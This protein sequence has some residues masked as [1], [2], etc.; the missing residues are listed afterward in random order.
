[1]TTAITAL[2]RGPY[3]IPFRKMSALPTVSPS[4]RSQ[5]KRPGEK[6]LQ[7]E[8]PLQMA[9]KANRLICLRVCGKSYVTFRWV[10]GG[11]NPARPP[12]PPWPIRSRGIETMLIANAVVDS[13]RHH[14]EGKEMEREG[15]VGGGRRRC[16]PSGARARRKRACLAASLFL[17]RSPWRYVY[18]RAEMW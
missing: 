12:I 11:G 4:R 7:Q 6:E 15:G 1:M 10:S 13:R 2:G 14:D 17:L 16:F 8:C 9:N 18:P 5:N 3:P